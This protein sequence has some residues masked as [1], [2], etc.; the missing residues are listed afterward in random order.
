ML[1]AGKGYCKIIP[2]VGLTN[3]VFDYEGEKLRHVSVE[4]EI[5]KEPEGSRVFYQEP[6]QI[7]TGTVNGVVDFGKFG[8]GNYLAHVTLVDKGNKLDKHLPFSVGIEDESDWDIVPFLI[9]IAVLVIA[10]IIM[11]WMARSKKSKMVQ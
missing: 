5:T 1:T 2:K 4:F 7:S 11:M 9:L 6:R 10:V 3:L 8:P